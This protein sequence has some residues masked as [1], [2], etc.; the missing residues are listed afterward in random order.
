MDRE[1]LTART[2]RFLRALYEDGAPLAELLRG[3]DDV[4]F[5]WIGA[6]RKECFDGPES[7]VR[8]WD[9]EKK[10]ESRPHLAVTDLVMDAQAAGESAAA[11][12][13]A[14]RLAGDRSTRRQRGTFV[15]R[16]RAGRWLLAHVHLS[17]PWALVWG[18]E[19]FPVTAARMNGEYLAAA[20]Q[21]E[22][23]PLP[24]QVPAKQRR[25]LRRLRQGLTY[26]EI[27]EVLGIS[28]RTV[29]YYVSEL[30]HRF[31]V[32]NKAQL[33]AASRGLDEIADEEKEE[34]P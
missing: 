24:A 25:V 20:R 30:I 13:A 19:R 31:H 3:A 11:V 29:R 18:D 1:E 7:L 14:W 21:D 2:E 16:L 15:Y 26:K 9:R 10:D 12:L 23:P 27:G 28:P 4:D 32:E 22:T 33:L 17:Q 6:E 5:S 34:T 8:W